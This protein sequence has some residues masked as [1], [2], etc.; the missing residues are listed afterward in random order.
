[1]LYLSIWEHSENLR[2]GL[3]FYTK[4]RILKKSTVAVIMNDMT[5]I[6]TILNMSGRRPADKRDCLV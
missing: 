2:L 6:I 5:Q 3:W 4:Q 1:M